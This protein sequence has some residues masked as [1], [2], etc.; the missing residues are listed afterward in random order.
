[1]KRVVVNLKVLVFG[2][3][4]VLILSRGMIFSYGD[5]I[6]Q[7]NQQEIA[8]MYSRLYSNNGISYNKQP[9][10]TKPYVVGEV[11]SASKLEG[12]NMVNLVRYVAGLPGDITLNEE[13]NI[14]AQNASVLVAANNQLSHFPEKPSDMSQSMYDLGYKGTSS[15]NLAW[16]YQSI[17][18]SVLG[19]MSDADA[20]NVEL[21]GHR[22]W[23]L[24][25]ELKQVGMGYAG[26]FSALY[27]FDWSREKVINYDGIKWPAVQM[28]VEL[29]NSHDPWSVNLGD[30]YSDPIIDSVKIKITR[31]NDGK[32][33]MIDNSKTLNEGDVLSVNNEG[34]GIKKCIIFRCGDMKINPGDKYNVAISGINYSDGTPT[35]YSY[36][37]NFFSINNPNTEKTNISETKVDNISSK[38]YTGKS[39]CPDISAKYNGSRLVKGVDYILS[40]KNNQN[41][42]KASIIVTG[43]GKYKGTLVKTFNIR[44]TK[45]TGLKIY[46]AYSSSIILNWNKK[47]N[48]YGYEI[49]RYVSNTYKKIGTVKPGEKIQYKDR[50][51]LSGKTYSYKIRCYKNINGIVYRSDLSTS[52]KISTN[53]AKATIS[54]IYSSIK[55]NAKLTW[56][57][58]TG[59]STYEIYM[60]SSY[61]GK[62]TKM[63]TTSS[64]NTCYKT[65]TTLTSGKKYYF[66]VRGY[67]VLNGRKYYGGF[68]NI[69]SIIVK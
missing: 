29:F 50:D 19:Y 5:D 52:V 54:T 55:G 39:I 16:G 33:W 56:K 25:P 24:N 61:S 60:S 3:L 21:V 32:T 57:K 38:V 37:V 41:V 49:Y 7:P 35:T 11:S 14:Y 1:M 13:Y 64:G 47:S 6:Q 65:I 30:K 62:Y 53:P 28:P 58:I 2:I 48:D 4:S 22:R 66:K 23:I 8:E 63:Y 43:K 45:V 27:V 46:Q 34:Y 44:P 12:L 69:K 26:T 67:K 17:A 9:S 68:S 51:L 10:F 20:Y 42:G 59:V 36:T 15:S 31:A 40:Y 18:S